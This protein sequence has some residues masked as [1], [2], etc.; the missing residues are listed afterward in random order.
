MKDID[1]FRRQ[2]KRGIIP[3]AVLTFALIR[4]P[5]EEERARNNY[6]SFHDFSEKRRLRKE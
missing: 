4:G 5:K 3:A 2:P 6:L 1:S